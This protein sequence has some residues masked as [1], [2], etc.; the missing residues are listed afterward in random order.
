MMPPVVRHY[1]FDNG[2]EPV[3]RSAQW[4]HFSLALLALLLVLA[5]CGG[6]GSYEWDWAALAPYWRKFL[7]GWKMTVAISAAALVLSSFIGLL[8]A[9]ARRSSFLPLQA[10]SR[11]YVELIR[12]LPLLVLLII[13]YYF[14]ADGLGLQNRYVAGIIL[15]SLF[16]GAYQSEIIRSGIES[17]GATQWE[18]A[19][20]IGL[21]TRQTY[22]Y[23]ILP[24][25]IRQIL[26]PMAGQFVSLVKDSSL[27]SILAINELTRAAQDVQSFTYSPFEAYLPLT[28]GYLILTIPISLWTARLEKRLHFDT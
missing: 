19:R 7:D 15:L 9:L 21:T 2:K 28:V 22:R 18:S 12:S 13:G 17:I 25:A 6:V 3:P 11:L 20:A 24:Q 16:S 27:L 8:F 10:F 1:F 26:P 5:I 4:V 23:V 14:V